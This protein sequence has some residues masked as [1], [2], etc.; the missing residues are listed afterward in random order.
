MDNSDYNTKFFIFRT[1]RVHSG[2][3]TITARNTKGEDQADVEI[4]VLGTIFT[5]SLLLR[6]LECRHI[7]AVVQLSL[8][9][10]VMGKCWSIGKYSSNRIFD[11]AFVFCVLDL[12]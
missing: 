11:G 8:L 1:G 5:V 7:E 3:Y 10:W 9:G 4:L 6:Y 12:V 2:V